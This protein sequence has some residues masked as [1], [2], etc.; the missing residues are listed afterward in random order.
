MTLSDIAAGIEV[1]TRQR[2]RGV[3]TVDGTDADL[4]E[5]LAAHVEHLPCRPAAAA[6][7][8]RAYARGESVE[9]VARRA[10][11]APMTAAKTLHRCGEPGLSPLGPTARQVVR[12]WLAGDLSRADALA[13]TGAP[14]A[15]F[16]LAA[17]VESHDPVPPLV[18]ATE[19]ALT[20]ASNAT[21]AKREALAGT[22]SDA[23]DLR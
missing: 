10:A 9:T 21:V 20:P 7:V 15:E 3:P 19:A 16:A 5:R 13:L 1:T 17:Y 11:V 6:A 12:D 2:A 4:E 22:M 14:D 18:E 8:V 23:T